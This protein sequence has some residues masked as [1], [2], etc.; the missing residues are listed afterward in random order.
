MLRIPVWLGFL[1]AL[2]AT[3]AL[4]ERLERGERTKRQLT[5]LRDIE[6][7][8]FTLPTASTYPVKDGQLLHDTNG[9][10]Q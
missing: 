3:Y 7:L 6:V 9:A 2:V 5:T 10:H 8:E 4:D 1:F